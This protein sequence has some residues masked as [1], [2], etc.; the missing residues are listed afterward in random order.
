MILW[1]ITPDHFELL[2]RLSSISR[3]PRLEWS[4]FFSQWTGGKMKIR[5]EKAAVNISKLTVGKKA[6]R[7]DF[8]WKTSVRFIFCLQGTLNGNQNNWTCDMSTSCFVI[9]ILLH[10]YNI[11]QTEVISGFLFTFITHKLWEHLVGVFTV[12]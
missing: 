12:S 2:S 6:T 10:I 1:P 9:E 4:D 5:L 8:I 11:L 7:G 3:N